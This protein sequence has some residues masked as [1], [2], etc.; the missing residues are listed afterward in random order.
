VDC[1]SRKVRDARSN[2]I[3]EEKM[4][5][6]YTRFLFDLVIYIFKDMNLDSNMVKNFVNSYNKVVSSINSRDISIN[7]IRTISSEFLKEIYEN[8]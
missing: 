2:M 1:N 7:D 8:K 3:H 6:M 5:D 4:T